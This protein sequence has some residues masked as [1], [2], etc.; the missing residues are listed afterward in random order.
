MFGHSLFLSSLP[1]RM[2]SQEAKTKEV[3]SSSCFP[4]YRIPG[5]AGQD[6]HASSFLDFI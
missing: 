5:M 3:H 6:T 4:A 2:D 1:H